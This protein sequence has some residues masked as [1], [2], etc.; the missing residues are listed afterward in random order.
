MKLDLQVLE[1]CN[2][3]SGAAK[4]GTAAATGLGRMAGRS[5]AGWHP[6]AGSRQEGASSSR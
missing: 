4:G 2:L 5:Q 3:H 6:G 1:N